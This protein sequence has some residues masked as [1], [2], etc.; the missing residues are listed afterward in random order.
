MTFILIMLTWIFLLGEDVKFPDWL[1]LLI[2]CSC[3]VSHFTIQSAAVS[4]LLDLVSLTKTVMEQDRVKG[5]GSEVTVRDNDAEQ[6]QVMVENEE[7]V[8]ARER[9]I[10]EGRVSVV[11]IPVLS[12]GHLNCLQ[13][14]TGF[15]KVCSKLD[16][17]CERWRKFFLKTV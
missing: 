11:I 9:R 5:L 13:E 16:F 12:P 4:T 1:K 15:Y 7:E 8:W 3:F 6:G 10:S 14:Q 2:T 17:C